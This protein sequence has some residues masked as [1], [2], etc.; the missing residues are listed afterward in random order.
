MLNSS[1]FKPMGFSSVSFSQI[2]EGQ[3][4][5][6]T[7]KLLPCSSLLNAASCSKHPLTWTITFSLGCPR[8]RGSLLPLWDFSLPFDVC[9]HRDV[10]LVSIVCPQEGNPGVTPCSSSVSKRLLI[11]SSYL[12]GR[13][14]L[15]Y[16]V[17]ERMML[18]T[19]CCSLRARYWVHLYADSRKG[20]KR[21]AKLVWILYPDRGNLGRIGGGSHSSSG[22]RI[23]GVS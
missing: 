10:L 15:H 4:C 20:K 18:I 7:V 23:M 5:L 8:G 3:G 12:R 17:K 13:C 19:Q 22:K 9:T 1:H 2:W 6:R 21:T 11:R 16:G 14:L